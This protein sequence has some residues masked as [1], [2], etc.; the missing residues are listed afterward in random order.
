MTFLSLLRS[1][2]LNIK[3]G[4]PGKAGRKVPMV[5]Q[6]KKVTWVMQGNQDPRERKDPQ[7]KKDPRE[8]KGY[9]VDNNMTMSLINYKF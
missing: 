8:K 4:L 3:I 1:C 9:Q 2:E 6:E 5:F 7:G